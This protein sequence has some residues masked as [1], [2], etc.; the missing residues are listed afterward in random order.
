MLPDI[1]VKG[2]DN[3]P[4]NIPGGE[5]VREAGGRVE[6]MSYVD[7]VSTTN[8]IGAIRASEKKSG[9]K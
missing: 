1:L 2:G 6:V 5:C 7:N 3:D 8:I 4:N 9:S